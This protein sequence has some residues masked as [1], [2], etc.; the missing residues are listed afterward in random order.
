V[1]KLKKG[2]IYVITEDLSSLL[3]EGTVVVV[4]E[5]FEEYTQI[6]LVCPPENTIIDTYKI[7]TS[8]DSKLFFLYW[9]RYRE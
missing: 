5:I 4:E 2:G 6:R 8:L 9:E 1:L 3:E 7:H